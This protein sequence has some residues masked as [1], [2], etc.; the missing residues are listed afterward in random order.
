MGTRLFQGTTLLAMFLLTAGVMVLWAQ[1]K[2][3]K[4]SPVEV[5]IK[6]TPP[7]RIVYL[8]H[9][10]S[11]SELEPV[12]TKVMGYAM[13]KNLELVGPMAGIYYDD[14][15]QVAASEL[16]SEI[17]V[18]IKGEPELDPPFRIKEIPSQEV[19]YALLKGPYDQIAL[20]YPEII[21]SLEEQGYKIVGPII[22]IYLVSGPDISPEKYQTE[23]WFPIGK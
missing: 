8:E 16:R 13:E 7:M 6:T 11:Y 10:G 19:G 3:A 2:E 5:K 23:V 12:F 21:S 18:Q 22:E 4:M 1:E 14:P 15:A 20:H 17:G 9:K